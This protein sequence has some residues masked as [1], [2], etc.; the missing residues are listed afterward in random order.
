MYKEGATT[1]GTFLLRDRKVRSKGAGSRLP[2]VTF[3]VPEEGTTTAPTTLSFYVLGRCV[4]P[5]AKALGRA[6][7]IDPECTAG[8][9]RKELSMTRQTAHLFVSFVIYIF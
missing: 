9:I 5:P 3:R 6:L 8:Y 2:Y 4:L 1:N 7:P